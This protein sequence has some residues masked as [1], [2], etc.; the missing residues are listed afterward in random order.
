LL[1]ASAENITL[2]MLLRGTGEKLI[3]SVAAVDKEK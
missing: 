3:A 2:L 1:V